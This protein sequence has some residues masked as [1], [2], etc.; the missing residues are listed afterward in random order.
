MHDIHAVAIR[1]DITGET[2]TVGHI[3]NSKFIKLLC[4]YFISLRT[5]K[6]LY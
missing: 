1:K 3:W 5:R 2:E 4:K 6:N